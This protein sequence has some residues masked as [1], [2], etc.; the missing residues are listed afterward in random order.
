MRSVLLLVS[1]LG[2][3]T[4]TAGQEFP[5]EL[6]HDGMVV[7]LEGDTLAGN[8]KYD[9]QSD[10]VMFSVNEKIQTLSARKLAYFEIFDGTIKEYRRFYALPY[11]SIGSYRTPIF[12]ELL[13]EGKLT[14]LSRESVEYRTNNSYF[15]YYS[16]YTRRVL[17]NRYYFLR[18]NGGI[19]EFKGSK[20][21][22]LQLMGRASDEVADY[23]KENKLKH[24]D[25]ADLAKAVRYYNSFF[26]PK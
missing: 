2:L 3:S 20:A 14:L 7:L 24:D 8:I 13:A 18:E 21:D 12:F 5:F 17:V 11:S 1:V 15:Y 23:M 19:E 16:T 10:I 22:L 26:L 25:K 6:W 9:M 4:V